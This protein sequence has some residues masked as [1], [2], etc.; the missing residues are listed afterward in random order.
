MIHDL[1]LAMQSSLPFSLAWRRARHIRNGH[2]FNVT[3]IDKLTSEKHPHSSAGCVYT[4]NV[5]RCDDCGLTFND[6][7][8]EWR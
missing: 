5:M 6:C 8:L 7:G 2:G 3:R 1:L 4:V